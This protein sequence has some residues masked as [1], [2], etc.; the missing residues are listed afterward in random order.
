MEQSVAHTKTEFFS[1]QNLP[2][3]VFWSLACGLLFLNLGVKGI[4]GS[5]ARWAAIVRE[6]FQSG[7]F[8]QP[9]INFE[10]YF[11]KPILSYWF[12]ALC[13]IFNNGIVNELIARIP[14]ALA[15]LATLWATRA[16]T[17]HLWGRTAAQTAGWI[18]LTIY[19]LAFWGRLAEADMLNTA[20]STLAV[21]WYIRNRE[22]TSF[23]P[24]LIFGALCAVGGQ[25]KGLSAI[26]VPVLVVLV[27]LLINRSWKKHLNI[28]FF[29]AGI[30]SVLLYF[31]PFLLVALKNG[32]TSFNGIYLVFRE[33]ITRFVAPFDHKGDW[34]DYFKYL[35]QLFL[36]WTP[37]LILA[38]AWACRKWK[39]LSADERWLTISIAAIFVMFSLSGSK[40][41]Y[42][43]L[44]ILPYCAILTALYLCR[45]ESGWLER[46]KRV[47]MNIY[48]YVFLA[49]GCL[50]LLLSLLWFSGKHLF[51]FV[52][53]QSIHLLIYGAPLPLGLLFIFLFLYF[54]KRESTCGVQRDFCPCPGFPATAVSCAVLLIFV[55]GLVIPLVDSEFRTGKPF[56]LEAAREM[57]ESGISQSDVAYLAKNYSNMSYYLAFGERIEILAQDFP[58]NDLEKKLCAYFKNAGNKPV[59]VIAEYRDWQQIQTPALRKI[60]QDNVFMAE[61][62]RKWETRG[63]RREKYVII[64]LNFPEQNR[65]KITI[66][67]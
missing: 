65:R 52:L 46:T 1:R 13:A 7:N 53:P 28:R 38:L 58:G 23:V 31:L 48:Q 66:F 64:A 37:F 5:E 29:T 32:D 47:L 27:D 14:S 25:T 17:E 26:A 20:F 36:P 55:F 12:I 10:L 49:G 34:Y 18:M 11:D 50:V 62:V 63:H 24:Y 21:A 59:A 19:S 3:L 35:P 39:A 51:P 33:N 15:A 57:K 67:Q 41:V 2:N 4:S 45:T 56:I 9:S 30:A 43:I 22:K 8:F 42:Y 60:I 44:P 6:M 61:P 54:R 16:I 40:R